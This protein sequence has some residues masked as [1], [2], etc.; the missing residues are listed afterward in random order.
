MPDDNKKEEEKKGL[1][2]RLP[3]SGRPFSGKIRARTQIGVSV[4]TKLWLRLRALAIR[5]GM[6]ARDLLDQAI[7]SFLKGKESR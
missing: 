5:Q 1:T 2:R 4:D 3:S 7:E 6:S